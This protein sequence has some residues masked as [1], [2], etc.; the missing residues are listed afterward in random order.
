LKAESG[1]RERILGESVRLFSEKGYHGASMR[2]ISGA[3]ACSLPML[4]YYFK[5]KDELFYAV[6]Y[7]EFVLLT[8]RLNREIAPDGGIREVYIQAL[9]QRK[10]LNSYDRAVY[11]L[12]LKVW[13]G[14]DGDTKVRR[15]LTAWE[16]GRVE[17]T[18][19]ILARH[20]TDPAKLEVI[21]SLLSRVL[22]NMME[23]ILLLDEDI[24]DEAIR[25]E[26]ECLMTLLDR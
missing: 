12:S 23:K 4:Y 19:Y 13:L 16:N 26:I 8:E 5:S 15:D 6:A 17:R 11:K 7:S 18:R 10:A 14:F 24:P 2:D 3:A 20:I 1:I 9:K 25:G 21:S 22:E